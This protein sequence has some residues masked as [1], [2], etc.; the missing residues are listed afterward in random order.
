VTE[1]WIERW[2]Q[3]RIGW[4]EPGGNGYLQRHWPRLDPGSTVLVPLCGKSVDLVWL[5]SHG[6]CVIGV[7]LSEIAIMSF[8]AENELDFSVCRDG[9]LDCY[10]ATSIP[11][12]IYCGDYFDYEAKPADALFDR[13]ALSAI[14][15]RIRPRYVERTKALLAPNAK[16]MIIALEFDQDKVAGPPFSVLPEELALY[17]PDLQRIDSHDDLENSP[18]KFRA[19]GLPEFREV[20]W[21]SK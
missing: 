5:A 10:S 14:P 11:I 1:D 17:W 19:A 21:L 4:H 16:R 15:A 20:V 12:R 3:G 2:Q 9:R 7:E 13:G 6:L 8:F 18:P